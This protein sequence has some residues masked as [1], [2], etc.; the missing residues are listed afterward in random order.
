MKQ[1]VIYKITNLINQKIYIGKDSTNRKNYY[2]SGK[3]IKNAILKYGEDNFSKEIID[4]AC[5]WTSS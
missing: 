1:R 2:G 5:V 4:T 3:A